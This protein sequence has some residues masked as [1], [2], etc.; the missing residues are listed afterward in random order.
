MMAFFPSAPSMAVIRSLSVVVWLS[1]RLKTSQSG[2]LVGEAGGDALEDV[3]DVGVIA[4]RAAVAELV[5]RLAGVDGFGERMDGEIGP[6]ARTID[7]EET[8]VDRAQAIEVRVV[9][10]ELFAGELG[11]RRKARSWR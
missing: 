6:L 5:D 3:V 8:Q 11:G 2:A 7:G 1:P 10:A 4:A 9:R